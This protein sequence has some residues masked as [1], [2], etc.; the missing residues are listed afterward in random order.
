LAA[1][2]TPIKADLRAT[3]VPDDPNARQGRVLLLQSITLQ[4]DD[5]EKLSVA[6][7]G[8]NLDPLWTK[9]AEARA[10]DGD[11]MRHLRL[12]SCSASNAVNATLG[13]GTYFADRGVDFGVA[14]SGYRRD[15]RRP[16]RMVSGAER[17]VALP[18]DR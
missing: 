5:A 10:L 17:L 16:R 11:A 6:P 1:R 12:A 7:A 3:P 14:N 13:G 18:P 4:L 9:Y 15:S 2:L 8:A